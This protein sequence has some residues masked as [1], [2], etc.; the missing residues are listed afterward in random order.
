M[1]FFLRIRRPPRSTRTDTLFPYTTLFRSAGPPAAWA[2]PPPRRPRPSERRG[3]FPHARRT[4]PG[5]PPTGSPDF[6]V[7]GI[8]E[9]LLLLPDD[10]RRREEQHQLL[11]G[12][13]LDRRGQVLILQPSSEWHTSELPPLKRTS[14]A[15]FL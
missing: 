10:P 14:F 3:P 6:L 7:A 4:A 11:S 5:A 8:R 2:R 13:P 1:F 12:E 15:G 9:D